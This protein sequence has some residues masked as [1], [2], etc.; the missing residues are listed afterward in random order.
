[1]A[2]IFKRTKKKGEP[3]TIQYVDYD[4]KRKT[5]PG[6]TD[7]GLTSE[8]A[9][10]LEGEVRLRRTGLIDPSLDAIAQARS[11]SLELVLA[12]FKKSLVDT[13]PK[14]ID[15]TLGR[16][17]RVF[18]G[19]M[20]LK[21]GDVDSAKLLDFLQTQRQQKRFGHRTY[22]HYLQA[23]GTLFTWC[24]DQGLLK[25]NPVATIEK[26][27]TEVDVRHPRRA[28]KPDEVKALI[29]SASKSKRSYQMQSPETRVRIYTI[30][31]M[32]GLRKQELASLTP[33]SFKL[34][35]NP[36]TV[37]VE[38]KRSKHRKKDV[39]PLHQELVSLLRVWL[40][41]MP[42]DQPL[43]PGLARKKLSNM[44]RLDLKGTDIPYRNIDGIADFH[45]AGR[46][47]Y[48]TEVIKS[49]APLP[50]AMELARHSD[51]KMTMR[52]THI[53][54]KDQADALKNLPSVSVSGSA[55]HG[56]C[57]SGVVA[58]PNVAQTATNKNCD[59][60]ERRRKSKP[61]A[62]F[63]VDCHKLAFATTA[64]DTGLEPATPYGA[65][66]FQ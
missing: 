38:A 31:Y 18:T 6:F 62:D 55:L 47:T 7:K 33:E 26:L 61:L 29:A 39:L 9:K 24:I 20:F 50:T 65:L 36:P 34:D 8:L 28:L 4:G 45:A 3:Y 32:T 59:S 52:Y 56:R 16:I 21:V 48:I 19:C 30:A 23:L 40:K 49:G 13:T 44:V 60:N 51:I 53:S 41:G 5:V 42:S 35:D 15:L 27:N 14:Y 17:E 66:H 25:S 58:S 10:K 2:S 57:I 12:D 43:F 64:E 46:H 22:N 1:M 63:G 11:K 54:I 37:T